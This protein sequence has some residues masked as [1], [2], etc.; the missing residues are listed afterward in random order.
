MI[1]DSTNTFRPKR[2]VAIESQFFRHDPSILACALEVL[3]A[4]DADR[5]MPYSIAF[6]SVSLLVPF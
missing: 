5:H 4:I 2:R 1:V 6:A 3:S